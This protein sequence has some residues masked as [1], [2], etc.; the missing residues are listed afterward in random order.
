MKKP[1]P[2]PIF[3]KR[4][5]QYRL[6]FCYKRKQ[7]KRFYIT[8]KNIAY[9]RQARVNYQIQSFKKGLLT[10]PSGIPLED[11]IFDDIQELN[12]VPDSTISLFGLIDEYISLF[13]PKEKPESSHKTE[14]THL[15]HL[16]R[17]CQENEYGNIF[18][19]NITI[20]FFDRYKQWRFGHDIQNNTLRKELATFKNIFK[21][22]KTYG[23]IDENI[24][25]KVEKPPKDEK[26]CFRTL[27][28]VEEVVKKRKYSDKEL[29][30]IRRFVY[31]TDDE[32]KELIDVAIKYYNSNHWL[33][34]ILITYA[35]SGARK[36]ELINLCWDSVNIPKEYIVLHSQKQSKTKRSEARYVPMTQKLKETLLKQ[37]EKIKGEIWV[38]PGP[39]GGQL[40]KHTLRSAFAR[41]IKNS[42]FE[43]IGLHLLRHSLAS[44]LNKY[45]ATPSN[46]ASILGHKTSVM[47]EYYTHIYLDDLRKDM[48]RL[49]KRNKEVD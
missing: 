24:L 19:H 37:K 21:K 14:L 27:A 4:V 1:K 12:P 5:N 29:K 35:E 32:V 23:Y 47:Q 18:L 7:Y 49:N 11:F 33:I 10:C 26:I 43:G 45:G 8:N 44:I 28:Q 41:M 16:K 30:K 9:I 3:E 46:I 36:S 34:P 40:S 48:N 6:Q 38:F 42:K 13:S 25:E 39:N 15:R 31:L 22:A 20:K 17:F 2:G